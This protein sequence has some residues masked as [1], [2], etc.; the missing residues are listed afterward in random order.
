VLTAS[1]AARLGGAGLVASAFLLLLGRGRAGSLLALGPAW[2]LEV[3]G[4]GVYAVG[5]LAALAVAALL[6]WLAG[7][8]R[9][10]RRAGRAGAPAPPA[11][12]G[13]QAVLAVLAVLVLLALV[14]LRGAPDR[15]DAVL[16]AAGLAA[17]S[18][19]VGYVV[20]EQPAG[21]H[22]AA[23]VSLVA[24]VHAAVAVG[25]VLRQRDLG[26]PA[27]GEVRLDPDAPGA[28]V[29]DLGR[30]HLLRGHGLTGH[31]NVAGGI[32]A[33]GLVAAAWLWREDAGGRRRAWAA[34]AALVAAGLLATLSRAAWLAAA[35]G[36]AWLLAATPARP[37]ARPA[38]PR[39]RR[40]RAV[41]WALAALAAAA[42]AVPSLH[43]VLVVRTLRGLSGAS[44]IERRSLDER[45]DQLRTAAA[46][47]ARHPFLGV[48]TRRYLAA[49][50]RARPEGGETTTPHSV[51]LLLA[52]EN[53][54]PAGLAWLALGALVLAAGWRA[55]RAEEPPGGAG[56]AL[57]LACAWM[58]ALQVES[59]LQPV[60]A[61]TQNLQAPV[62]L[63]L[64]V[65][66]WLTAAS[67]RAGPA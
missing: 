48:G 47:I 59:L 54:V 12:R 3:P 67:A 34:L 19:V 24:A 10:R 51:P 16:A 13:V 26:L 38:R 43:E 18:L 15:A 41:A 17:L 62:W 1:G 53:G 39:M 5:P 14:G 57:A 33:L 45:V 56:A 22:V 32:L 63:G 31:P 21:R 2:R 9:G 44:P 8:V 42:V 36:V 35:A 7:R 55:R 40:G 11:V 64:V 27:L 58:A 30:G 65:G 6:L 23:F 28:A 20:V 37:R 29:A 66:L 61:P 52:A 60:F 4:R 50:E 25:Q 46:L 49:A